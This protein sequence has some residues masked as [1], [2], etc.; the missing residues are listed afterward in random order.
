M[1]I[2]DEYLDVLQ[3]L[4]FAIISVYREQNELLDYDVDE[5]LEALISDYKAENTQREPKPHS[6]TGRPLDVYNAVKPMCEWRLGRKPIEAEVVSDLDSVPEPEP[7]EIE[8][9][10]AC[11][12]RLRKSVKLWTKE[13]GR[14][15]YLQFVDPYIK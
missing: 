9:L 3:N 15:G 13:S 7:L 14:Q 5:A 11:L 4:E 12:K 8:E 6:L 1:G 2:E 10:L